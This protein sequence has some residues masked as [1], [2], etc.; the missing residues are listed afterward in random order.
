[1]FSTEKINGVVTFLDSQV[2]PDT[3]EDKVPLEELKKHVD[4]FLKSKAVKLVS[5]LKP[6]TITLRQLYEM[7][8][9]ELKP[10]TG[11]IELKRILEFILK[12]AIPRKPMFL[13]YKIMIGVSS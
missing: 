6:P 12:K 2:I 7:L 13:T 10:G 3:L 1:M 11:M 9:Q 5:T 4:V 8:Q